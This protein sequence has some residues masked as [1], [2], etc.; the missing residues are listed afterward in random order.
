M[1]VF[2]LII[3]INVNW[4]IVSQ[5]CP[6]GGLSYFEFGRALRPVGVRMA[7]DLAPQWVPGWNVPALSRGIGHALPPMAEQILGNVYAWCLESDRYVQLEKT[8]KCKGRNGPDPA[9]V[10][11]LITSVSVKTMRSLI[12]RLGLDSDSIRVAGITPSTRS[13]LIS[14]RWVANAAA[15]RKLHGGTCGSR[16][17]K[18][19]PDMPTIPLA[20]AQLPAIAAI[21]SLKDSQPLPTLAAAATP[22]V[23]ARGVD[24]GDAVSDW[25]D[26][27]PSDEEA[28]QSKMEKWR[29]H[30]HFSV[31]IRMAELATFWFTS[32]LAI[33]KFPLFVSWMS[34]RFSDSVGDTNHSRNWVRH[35]PHPVHGIYFVRFTLRV[36]FRNI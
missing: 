33:D 15:K 24:E 9:R 34:N 20:V 2:S 1:F 30:P 29:Q 35:R 10:A 8:L 19:K 7:A 28:R 21:S 25:L 31:G 14:K 13:A 32:G 36:G 11:A 27:V 17:V 12:L 18:H 16:A 22:L 5:G 3:I 26:G 23:E 4:F 6:L